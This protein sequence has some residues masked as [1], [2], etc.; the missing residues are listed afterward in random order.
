MVSVELCGGAFEIFDSE[1]R[2]AVI[3]DLARRCVR[4]IIN[5]EIAD[6]N[7]QIILDQLLVGY[8]GILDPVEI[9]RKLIVDKDP[10]KVFLLARANADVMRQVEISY[11][12]LMCFCVDPNAKEYLESLKFLYPYSEHHNELSM[13]IK[14]IR[15][16]HDD[17]KS[18]AEKYDYVVKLL[19]PPQ[20]AVRASSVQKYCLKCQCCNH[21]IKQDLNVCGSCLAYPKATQ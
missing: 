6:K 9:V 10:L 20:P 1:I 4:K 12:L 8:V 21:Y 15:Q 17:T 13:L 14:F 18:R 5:G 19:S 3:Q 7:D 2:T 16:L 11:E